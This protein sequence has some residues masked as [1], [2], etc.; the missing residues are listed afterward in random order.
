M[1]EKDM[2]LILRNMES[3]SSTI[4]DSQVETIKYID[5]VYEDNSI[6]LLNKCGLLYRGEICT[7]SVK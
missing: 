7:K 2:D 4:I 6:N 5:D 3:L 1:I